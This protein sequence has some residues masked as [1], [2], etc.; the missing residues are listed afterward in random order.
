MMTSI[1]QDLRQK[2]R[3]GN[4]IIRLIF[5]NV[6]IFVLVGLVKV[7]LFLGGADYLILEFNNFLKDWFFLPSDLWKLASRPW[8]LFTYMFF[9]GDVSHLFFNMLVLYTFG[10]IF[11]DLLSNQR[12]VPLYL[13]GGLLGGFFFLVAFNTIPRLDTTVSI[14][15]LGASASIVAFVLAAATFNPRGQVGLLF[16]GLIELRYVA[17]FMCLM[18]LLLVP[19]GNVG[20]QF[21]HIG[22]AVM[23]YLYITLLR[24]GTD[25][26]R[27]INQFFGWVNNLFKPKVIQKT[28]QPKREPQPAFQRNN[29]SNPQPQPTKPLSSNP[30]TRPAKTNNPEMQGYGK[31]FLQQYKDLSRQECVDAIL[32]K[33]HQVGYTN[34]SE[35]EQKFL[36]NASKK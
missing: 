31:A 14:P 15:L 19:S 1:W 25:L 36:A 23:G 4:N 30:E 28:S 8:T 20:G 34:L 7:P 5:I 29:Q 16:F 13:L 10:N 33:I 3:T 32:E 11:A 26:A 9:H 27:P 22:G 35:D 2:Y 21:A 17:F 6:V 24:K 18:Y 12:V